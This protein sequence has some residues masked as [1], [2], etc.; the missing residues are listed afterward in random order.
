MA[1]IS[2][3][4]LFDLLKENGKN[5]KD[6]E[7]L[8]DMV[9]ADSSFNYSE[10]ARNHLYDP[11]RI[12]CNNLYKK[13]CDANRTYK[14]FIKK[15][16]TWLNKKFNIPKEALEIVSVEVGSSKPKKTKPF[17]QLSYKQKKRRTETLR[18]N[19]NAEMSWLLLQ[20]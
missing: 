4:D 3:Y 9:L 1:S 18:T 15:Y 17:N 14:N 13:W 7:A 11:I 10:H 2:Y 5:L 6:H 20:K 19:N 8:L 16:Q 12:F